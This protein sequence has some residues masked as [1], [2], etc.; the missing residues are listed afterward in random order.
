[1][2]DTTTPE[3]LSMEFLLNNNVFE[4]KTEDEI[5][6]IN[7]RCKPL[8]MGVG[9]AIALCAEMGGDIRI[10][11]ATAFAALT[12]SAMRR[13]LHEDASYLT[14]LAMATS[15]DPMGPI[16]LAQGEVYIG[17][18]AK[19]GEKI[20]EHLRE[21]FGIKEEIAKAGVEIRHEG[22]VVDASD[23]FRAKTETVH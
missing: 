23:L 4:N 13:G 15:R 17:G 21:R 12:E 3:P 18:V 10:A 22:N 2:T 14:T 19:Q 1:M 5:K 7:E 8:M 11:M 20:P 6:A 16:A 9:C